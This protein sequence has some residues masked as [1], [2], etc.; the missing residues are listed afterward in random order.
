MLGYRLGSAGG[1]VT[2]TDDEFRAQAGRVRGFAVDFS[3]EAGAGGVGEAC[4]KPANSVQYGPSVMVSTMV[5]VLTAAVSP[6]P[7]GGVGSAG[8]ADRMPDLQWLA[9]LISPRFLAFQWKNR[10]NQG[11]IP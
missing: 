2:E 4:A 1:A 9:R 10:G 5:F 7:V 6:L 3:G 8:H 11:Q